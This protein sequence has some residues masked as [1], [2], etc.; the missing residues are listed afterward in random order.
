MLKNVILKAL[1]LF[2]M[3]HIKELVI[4]FLDRIIPNKSCDSS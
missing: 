2:I 3:F 4:L 1:K